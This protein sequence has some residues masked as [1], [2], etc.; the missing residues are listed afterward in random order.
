MS[1]YMSGD[2]LGYKL[3][4][5]KKTL[6]KGVFVIAGV[7][8]AGILLGGCNA[9]SNKPPENNT[10]P[11]ATQN[12]QN[13]D[14]TTVNSK[15]AEYNNQLAGLLPSREGYKWRY[16]G[17]AEY[18]HEMTLVSIF[19]G[20]GETKFNIQGFVDDMSGGAGNFETGHFGIA[21]TYIIKDG[22]LRQEKVEK[23]MMDSDS[24]NIELLRGP[25]TL[26]SKW[27]QD[28][29]AKDGKKLKLD[30]EITEINDQNGVKTYTVMYKDK[31]SEYYEKRQIKE[32]AGVVSF[33][34]N[35]K[36]QEGKWYP[37]GYSIYAE[38][39]GYVSRLE[40]D[41]FLPPFDKLL[42]FAGLA[43]YSHE[44]K[45][46]KVSSDEN[47]AVYQFDGTFTDGS[48][49]PGTFKVQYSFDYVNGTISEKV[50]ENTRP[51]AKKE[52]NSKISEHII[53][54]FPVNAGTAWQQEV[55]VNGKKYLM[56]AKITSVA[57]RGRTEY[58]PGLTDH[59]RQYPVATVR[60]IVRDVPGYFNNTYIEERNFQVGRGMIGFSNLMAGDIGI[61]GKDLEDKSKVEEAV[62]MHMFGY[63]LNPVEQ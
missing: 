49:I 54:K 60:Y 55:T 33:E 46:K 37:I 52:V 40:L 44:G 4:Y 42:R 61:S 41:R 59:D 50:V 45:M 3:G 39:S 57:F 38:A 31:S 10:T 35:W 25:L 21:L 47:S 13:A 30:C 24:N 48:G 8:L 29:V 19:R 23:I 6:K 53:L 2:K 36:D 5:V 20:T 22:V 7:I 63:S 43:E 32:K 18:G 15:I 11:N 1:G 58:S 16:N 26:N 14:N 34:K 17:F 27:T 28:V 56:D 9:A 51:N 62:L 12:T